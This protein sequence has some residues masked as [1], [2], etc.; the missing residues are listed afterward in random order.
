MEDQNQDSVEEEVAPHETD[1]NES[2]MEAE[3]DPEHNQ[4]DDVQERNWRAMRQRQ[5]ELELEIQRRDE[6]LDRVL[7]SQPRQE[8]VIVEEPE[9]P[10]DEFI[11]AGKVRKIASKHVKPLEQKINELEEKLAKQENEKRFQSLRTK[12]SDFDDVVNIETLELLEKTDPE[13]ASTIQDIKDPYKMGIQA[14]KYIKATGLMS[15]LPNARRTKEID[16]RI[17]KNEKTVQT[18]LAYDKRPIAQA[19][20]TTAADQKRLYEEMMYYARQA[21]GL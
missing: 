7:K 8:P 21:S 4:E 3:A 12:Y 20:K 17:E 2:N 18:P 15:Q 10:D 19:M 9:D 1:L 11:P 5:K 16:K 13:L 6:V 14:Y